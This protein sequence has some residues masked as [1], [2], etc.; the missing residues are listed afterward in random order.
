M[1]FHT[2]VHAGLADSDV[3]DVIS[4]FRKVHAKRAE[5]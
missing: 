2:L 3:D 1:L 4:A 5:L